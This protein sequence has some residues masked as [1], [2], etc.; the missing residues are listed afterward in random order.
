MENQRD[1]V[2]E[3]EQQNNRNAPQQV[4][5]ALRISMPERATFNSAGQAAVSPAGSPDEPL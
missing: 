4:F 3:E 1:V 2:A 5:G